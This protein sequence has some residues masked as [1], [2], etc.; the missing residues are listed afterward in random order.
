M[1]DHKKIFWGWYVVF[2]GFLLLSLTYG[3]R[4]SFGVFVKP[5]FSQ[6]HWPMSIIS[7]GASINILMYAIGGV[8]SGRLVDRMAP[9]W[10]IMIGAITASL[11][12][13]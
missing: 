1:T 9:K 6:Y 13:F 2:G 5:M 7:L 8:L 10:I 11:G 3:T 4:Y 12:F